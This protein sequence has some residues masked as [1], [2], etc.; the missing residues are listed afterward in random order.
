MKR[1]VCLLMV[2]LLLLAGCTP[3]QSDPSE[4]TFEPFDTAETAFA[5]AWAYPCL[6]ADQQR[7]YA[8][9]YEA[10]VGG[11]TDETYVTVAVDGEDCSLRGV[12]VTL[13]VPLATEEEIVAL[14]DALVQDNPQFFHL[15]SIYGYDGR[16]YGDKRRLTALK[17]T[18]T[19]SAEQRVAAKQSIDE[20]TASLLSVLPHHRTAFETELALHDL[21]MSLCRYDTEAAS[22]T[23]PLTQHTVSFTVYGAL[24]GKAVCEGYSRAMQ[25]LLNK[26]GCPTTVVTGWDADGRPHMWNAVR[27]EGKVYHLDVTWNDAEEL[28]TYTYFNLNTD[29]IRRSH[30]MDDKTLGVPDSTDKDDNYYRA[31]DAYLETARIEDIASGI[32]LRLADGESVVHLRF[33]DAAF[34]QALFFVRSTAWF[35]DTVNAYAETGEP[36]LE[37]YTFTYNEIYKTVTISKKPLDIGA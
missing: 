29:E 1:Q 27:L 20:K 30:R 2:L 5:N 16:Q 33:S 12:S 17:L 28:P 7:N 15:G 32:A 6:S 21:L 23:A 3:S 18:Y 35:T 22:S 25:Y 34:D 14:Y 24:S 37:H 31:T 8:A 13:P 9:V 10:I 36:L 26:A 19:M 11:F 4:N